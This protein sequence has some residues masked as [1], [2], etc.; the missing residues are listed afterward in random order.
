LRVD[1]RRSREA[2]HWRPAMKQRAPG[3]VAIRIARRGVLDPLIA[4]AQNI[5]RRSKTRRPISVFSRSSLTNRDSSNLRASRNSPL[6]RLN[7]RNRSEKCPRR[8]RGISGSMLEGHWS[9][10]EAFARTVADKSAPAAAFLPVGADLSAIPAFSRRRFA[11]FANRHCSSKRPAVT[12][13]GMA[14]PGFTLTMA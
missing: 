3:L 9:A 8:R 12:T 7:R 1:G 4:W 10:R 13:S 6:R 2:A 14:S 11:Y 5:S